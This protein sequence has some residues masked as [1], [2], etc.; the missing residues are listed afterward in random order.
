MPKIVDHR[1]RRVE[2][3][4]VTARLIASR[5]LEAATIRAVARDSGYSKGV[6]EHYFDDKDDLI[7]VAL[8][9][10]NNCYEARVAE[11]TAGLVGLAALRRR[12]DSL[13]PMD[14]TTRVEWRVRLVF[15]SVAAIHED[16]RRQQARRF[17]KTLALF[18]SD[19]AAAH[20]AGE[21]P[22]RAELPLQVR[23]LVNRI[24]GL[25]VAALHSPAL[26]GRAVLQAE[27]DHIIDQLRHGE[28]G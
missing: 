17:R 23:R 13:L 27:I 1:E 4:A 9:W 25:S 19:I 8:E 15:W 16:L 5:G 28:G 21:C 6:V 7:S 20:A 11:T 10:A 26:H 12:I 18:Q 24:T 2:L 22:Q 3:S 14:P